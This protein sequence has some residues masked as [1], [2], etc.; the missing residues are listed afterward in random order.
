MNKYQQ[1]QEDKKERLLERASKVRA[2]GVRRQ[3]AGQFALEAIPFGQPI[4]VGH[5]SEKSD[6]SYRAKAL[7]NLDKGYA[8]IKEADQI[9][10]R[11]ERIGSGGIS[12]DDPEAIEKLEVE[13]VKAVKAQEMYK[14]I[15]QA[16]KKYLKDPESLNSVE[17]DFLSIEIKRMI[18]S[19]VPQYSHQKHPIQKFEITNNAANI[20]RIQKRI[21]D[22][23]AKASMSLREQVNGPGFSMREDLEDNRI[24]FVFDEKPGESVRSILKSRGFKWSPTRNAWVRQLNAN[25]RYSAER[26]IESLTKQA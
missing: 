6:R 25:G 13:L 10:D 12:S 4:L 19:Y 1:R 24:L 7:N 11:A 14:A 18:R 5:H 16:H 3:E 26:V 20:R 21:D 23:R 17:F 22:L 15:N 8:L 9:E 2:E